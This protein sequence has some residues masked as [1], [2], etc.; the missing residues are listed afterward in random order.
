MDDVRVRMRD[1]WGQV[2]EREA[3]LS[4]YEF[5]IPPSEVLVL[6]TSTWV[7]G[8]RGRAPQTATWKFF[9]SFNTVELFVVVDDES[10]YEGAAWEATGKADT[11]GR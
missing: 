3:I 11:S 6:S 7:Q 9:E 8:A 10:D 4:S 5:G 1:S 2:R